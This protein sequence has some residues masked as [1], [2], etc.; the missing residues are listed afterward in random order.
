MHKRP[1]KT[2]VPHLRKA[3][4]TAAKGPRRAPRRGRDKARAE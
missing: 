3:R 4:V 2:V 1:V